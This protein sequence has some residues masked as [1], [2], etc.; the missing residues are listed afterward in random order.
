MTVDLNIKD[1]VIEDMKSDLIVI[2]ST[3]YDR[4]IFFYM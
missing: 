4:N 2:F 1:D 3:C